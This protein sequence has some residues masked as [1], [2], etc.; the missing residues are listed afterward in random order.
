MGVVMVEQK[1]HPEEKRIGDQQGRGSG[2][3]QLDS[4]FCTYQQWNDNLEDM[5]DPGLSIMK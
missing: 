3:R 5:A 4:G 2:S 1:L